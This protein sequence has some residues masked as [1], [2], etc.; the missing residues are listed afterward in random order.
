MATETNILSLEHYYEE[1]QASCAPKQSRKACYLHACILF[2]PNGCH[3][4]FVSKLF[5]TGTVHTTKK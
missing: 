2:L 5:A 4:S 1:T 3:F